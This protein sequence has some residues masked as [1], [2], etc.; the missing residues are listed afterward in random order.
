[1]KR[2]VRQFLVKSILIGT[3]FLYSCNRHLYLS[4]NRHQQYRVDSSIDIDSD[5]IKHYLPYKQQLDQSMNQVLGYTDVDLTKPADPETLLGNFFT[6]ALME[7]VSDSFKIDFAIATKGGLRAEIAKGAITTEKIY[8]LMPFENKLVVLILNGNRVEELLKLI[9][10]KEGQP[11]SGISMKINKGAIDNVVIAGT[12]FDVNRQ[13]TILTYDYL[14]NGGDGITALDKPV[15][16][17][18]LDNT[19]RDVLIDHVK[20]I[21]KEGKHI[22][23]KLDGRITIEK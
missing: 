11:V 20:R 6:D 10:I 14:A 2:F 23:T 15:K 12:A 18:D 22:N 3:I 13:Y 1:M 17:I 4:G 7:E 19:V 5:V 9:A 8:E 21:A 16:R